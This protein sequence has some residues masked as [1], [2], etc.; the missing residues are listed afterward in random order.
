MLKNIVVFASGSGTNFQS[1]IDA[2]QRG[3]ITARIS[4]LIT[5]KDGIKAIERAKKNQIPAKVINPNNLDSEKDFESRLL[6]QLK[7]WNADLIV[8]AGYL[9]KIPSAV[10]ENYPNRILNIHPSLLPK[11]GGKGFY[12]TNVHKAVLKAGEKESGCSVHVVTE[13]FDEGPVLAQK[14][15]PVLQNDTPEEL[16]SRILKEEHKLYPD[17]IQKHLQTL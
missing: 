3:D 16:A 11:Y 4:G 12:G 14:T 1:I 10:I 13:E 6:N 8:L 7:E 5:N 15:V 9:K 17:T 2:V